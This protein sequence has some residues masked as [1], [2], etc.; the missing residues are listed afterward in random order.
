MPD[1]AED[2]IEKLINK[3]VLKIAASAGIRFPVL[4]QL[5]GSEGY[6]WAARVVV[7]PRIYTWTVGDVL[8]KAGQINPL[9]GPFLVPLAGV[10]KVLA[11]FEVIDDP[12]L[13]G[14]VQLTYRAPSP[15]GGDQ[16]GVDFA[17]DRYEVL[18]HITTPGLF[19][20]RRWMADLSL[21]T[22]HWTSKDLGKLFR[23]WLE[24]Y[25]IPWPSI[26]D[27]V[28]DA[29]R[30][31][32]DGRE[33]GQPAFEIQGVDFGAVQH[34]DR[35][36]QRQQR[37]PAAALQPQASPRVLD[38]DAAHGAAGRREEVGTTAG[39]DT[40]VIG[41]AQVGL[42]D[43]DGRREREAAPGAELAMRDDAEIFVDERQ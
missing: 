19:Q 8:E 39:R 26:A 30:P 9:F 36:V 31:V 41:K 28:T 24:I 18:N 2:Q 17:M 5:A 4:T 43:Q 23:D 7:N 27:P 12:A 34:G 10:V 33:L 14:S 6:T 32:R 13:A 16:F 11:A 3:I 1:I 22:W 29:C 15:S 21:T 20:D 42:V 40:R 37:Y 35:F 38:H 25:S